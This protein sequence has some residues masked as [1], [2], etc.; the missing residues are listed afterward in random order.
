MR[1]LILGGDGMLGHRLLMHLQRNH[2][3]RA[4]LRRDLSAYERYGL[5]TPDNSYAEVEV[6]DHGKLLETFADFHPEAVV[7]AVGIVK[8]RGA[9]KEAIPSLEINALLPH[10][11]ALLCKAAGVRLVHIST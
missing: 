3:V 6:R 8:Q 2:D 11:L 9:A 1:I 7:N 4:T 10:R 5:F